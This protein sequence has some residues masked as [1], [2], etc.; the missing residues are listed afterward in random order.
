MEKYFLSNIP[1][2]QLITANIVMVGTMVYQS[3]QTPQGTESYAWVQ[4]A[5]L[6]ASVGASVIGGISAKNKEK[7]AQR[8]RERREASEN[9]WYQRRYNEDYL[10]TKAGQNLIRKAN[11]MYKQGISRAEGAKAIGGGTDASVAASKERANKAIGDTIANIGANDTARKDRVDNIH[12]SN[13]QKFSDAKV[14]EYQRQANNVT[15]A[16]QN[17]SNAF[18]SA[19]ASISGEQKPTTTT[20]STPTSTE[21]PTQAPTIKDVTSN[22][23]EQATKTKIGGIDAPTSIPS[24]VK[25]RTGGNDAEMWNDL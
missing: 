21:P 17:A 18:M 8:E 23:L 3:F 7:K 10:D 19:A 12:Q 1:K 4:L 25:L 13:E 15:Q 16:A 6:A 22:D 9:A 5:A 20:P 11:E 14:Q 24:D 2:W